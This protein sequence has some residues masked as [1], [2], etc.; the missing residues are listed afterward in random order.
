MFGNYSPL[1]NGQLAD[2]GFLALADFDVNNDYVIN[3][4]DAIFN[5]LRIW[6]DLNLDG[7]SSS[8][9]MFTLAQMNVQSLG[10][11]YASLG[12]VDEFGNYYADGNNTIDENGNQ[13]RQLGMFTKTDGTQSGM[14]DVWFVRDTSQRLDKSVISFSEEI[15]ALPE[16]E[17]F[18]NVHNLRQSMR[19]S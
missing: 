15:A 11:D 8:N 18:G 13:H 10:L 16:I 6:K 1:S 5:Q 12:Y 14:E 4:S 9:E 17:G 3:V 2:N 7:I 19:L